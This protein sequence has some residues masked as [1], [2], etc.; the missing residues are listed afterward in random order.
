MILAAARTARRGCGD[1]NKKKKQNKNTHHNY[2]CLP[3]MYASVNMLPSGNS[4]LLVLQERH[5]VL[6]SLHVFF[7][8]WT[9]FGREVDRFSVIQGK[10][11]NT[12]TPQYLQ[13]NI[14]SV[15]QQELYTRD[16]TPVPWT[17]NTSFTITPTL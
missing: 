11:L 9:W 6:V 4:L 17:V 8:C 14:Y 16:W 5:S 15:S 3:C 2:G 7:P 1:L 10:I 13:L 12:K